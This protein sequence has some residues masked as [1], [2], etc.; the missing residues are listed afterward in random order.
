MIVQIRV[1]FQILEE[2]I[3]AAKKKKKNCLFEGK[4]CISKKIVQP[5]IDLGVA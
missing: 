5:A 3:P 1:C 4:F 2:N